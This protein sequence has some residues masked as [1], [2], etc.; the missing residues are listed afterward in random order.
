MRGAAF[1]SGRR[2][3]QRGRPCR[4]RFFSTPQYFLGFGIFSLGTARRAGRRIGRLLAKRRGFRAFSARWRRR[5]RVALDRHRDRDAGGLPGLQELLH[6]AFEARLPLRRLGGA[7]DAAKACSRRSSS[8]AASGQFRQ[9]QS[10]KPSTTRWRPKQARSSVSSPSR[11]INAASLL[12]RTCASSRA[13]IIGPP[14]PPERS[15]PS[16]CGP[17]IWSCC[18]RVARPGRAFAARTDSREPPCRSCRAGWTSG[19]PIRQP[20]P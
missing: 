8:A 11:S 19:P 10:S 12:H 20:R 16:S 13:S 17:R 4:L 14:P 5:H 15:R 3:Y 2:K 6:D 9:S 18:P 7:D 1:M